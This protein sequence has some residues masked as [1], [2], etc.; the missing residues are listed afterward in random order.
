MLTEVKE[1]MCDTAPKDDDLLVAMSF[2]KAYHCIIKIT[3][4]MKWSGRYSVLVN[5]EDS[6]EDIKSRL[7]KLYGL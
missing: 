4:V 7:P 5:K 3:W 2:A 6:L 1:Y